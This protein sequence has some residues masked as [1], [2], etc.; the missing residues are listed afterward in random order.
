MADASPKP[1]RSAQLITL[2]ISS[3]AVLLPDLRRDAALPVRRNTRQGREGGTLL[4]P[5]FTICKEVNS[6]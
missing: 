3:R 6:T 2:A 1:C 4:N 5:Y